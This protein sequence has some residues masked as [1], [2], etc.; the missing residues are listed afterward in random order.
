M[1]TYLFAPVWL[2]RTE[3][4]E[5]AV[6]QPVELAYAVEHVRAIY[7]DGY[8]DH[9]WE[10][11]RGPWRLTAHD[12]SGLPQTGPS[13]GVRYDKDFHIPTSTIVFRS[14]HAGPPPLVESALARTSSLL[15]ALDH[16]EETTGVRPTLTDVWLT[17]L[18]AV[19]ALCWR[20]GE[21]FKPSKS[22]PFLWRDSDLPLCSRACWD[23]LA[24][25][26]KSAP[27]PRKF[28]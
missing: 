18:G 22:D 8:Q 21:E 11:R 15:V 23:A 27:T 12:T 13:A 17:G 3:T 10:P 28:A 5:R 4:P 14:Q 16:H 20:C 24:N 2:G 19:G 9:E 1:T 6:L 25:G 26:W 7:V